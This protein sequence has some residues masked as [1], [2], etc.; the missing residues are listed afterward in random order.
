MPNLVPHNWL[1]QAKL[2]RQEREKKKAAN[3]RVS[4]RRTQMLRQCRSNRTHAIDTVTM[5]LGRNQLVKARV[6]VH[7]EELRK[8]SENLKHGPYQHPR[9]DNPLEEPDT[10]GPEVV[11]DIPF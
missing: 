9:P 11:G 7:E 5:S 3:V 2:D 10:L 1:R 4:L 8:R 6:S